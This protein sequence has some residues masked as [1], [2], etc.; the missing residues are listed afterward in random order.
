M[1]I[2]RRPDA[3]VR[4]RR[5]WR[6]G[7]D[8]G[9]IAASALFGLA[10]DARRLL[11]DSGVLVGRPAPVPTLGI[12]S[13]T[14]GGS[15]KTPLSSM[16]ARWIRRRGVTPAVVTHGF[17]DEMA[18]H[19]RLC[20]GAVV[21]GRPRRREALE[22]ALE[23]G[24]GAAVLDDS[25]QHLEVRRDL[26]WVTVDP[27]AARAGRWR[28]L[29]AGPARERWGALERAT[30]V[31]GVVR[32]RP[33]PSAST[34]PP[35]DWRRWTDRLRRQLPGVPVALCGLHHAG[36]RP[37]NAAARER[38]DARP[39]VG[40]ATIMHGEEFLDGL[41]ARHPT[42]EREYLFRDHARL[43]D[44]TVEGLVDAAGDGGLVGTL[45][46]VVKVADRV[47]QRTPVWEAEEDLVWVEGRRTLRR[48]LFSILEET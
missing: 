6:E 33:V 22:A 45:K 47:G 4:V 2:D 31:V 30:A 46:D 24:A 11:Y 43:D 21:V 23:A 8:P 39:A 10:A 17:P 36:L 19:R 34:P 27:R 16:A 28:R 20:P 44:D 41:R 3:E 37:A 7:A 25:F 13:L 12:G 26:D 1:R 38:E 9:L 15:G 35:I 40:F 32:E 29:P 42:L 5:A 48:Q 14:V 18:V